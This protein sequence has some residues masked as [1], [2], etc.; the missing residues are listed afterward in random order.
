MRIRDPGWKK[1]E[2]GIRNR[3][4]TDQGSG[5]VKYGSGIR[6]E[7]PGSATLVGSLLNVQVITL[8]VQCT[9]ILSLK[10]RSIRSTF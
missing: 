7:P 5:M 8:V 3:K 4:N 6:D 10:I 1:Y 2:S 9:I